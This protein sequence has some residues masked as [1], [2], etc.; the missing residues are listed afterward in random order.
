[1]K[2][3][4]DSDSCCTYCNLD[5]PVAKFKLE[6]YGGWK[7]KD[8]RTW[9][10][11]DTRDKPIDMVYVEMG[12]NDLCQCDD[13]RLLAKHL[14][15]FADYLCESH[16]IKSVYLGQC[17]RRFQ[18]KDN[19]KYG[20][21]KTHLKQYNAL[22]VIFN[23]EISIRCKSMESG[24]VHYWSGGFWGPGSCRLFHND[25]IHLN[26]LGMKRYSVRHAILHA[27]NHVV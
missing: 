12:S 8:M 18:S 21:D 5:L 2:E 9:L 13:I 17:F 15:E 25:G 6:G 20:L 19:K 3:Y 16:G 1:M 23:R 14:A 27:S 7:I 11:S 24:K 26:K 22:V 4:I 10:P